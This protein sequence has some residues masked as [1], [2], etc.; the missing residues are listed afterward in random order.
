MDFTHIN[1]QSIHFGDTTLE[2]NWL[3]DFLRIDPKLIANILKYG[4]LDPIVVY[5]IDGELFCWRGTQRV[6]IAR[7]LKLPDVNILILDED[8][9]HIP[10]IKEVQKYFT[11]KIR[12]FWHPSIKKWDI[13]GEN[14]TGEPGTNILYQKIQPG[15]TPF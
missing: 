10:D 1:P 2:K 4:I 3:H 11:K 7:Y 12:I 14:E 6:R 9:Q 15:Y 8:E 13:L 5:T